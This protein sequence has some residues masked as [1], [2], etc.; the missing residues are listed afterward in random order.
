MPHCGKMFLTHTLCNVFKFCLTHL[1]LKYK[2][3]IAV[4][5]RQKSDY[6]VIRFYKRGGI[7]FWKNVVRDSTDFNSYS[8]LTYRLRTKYYIVYRF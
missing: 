3:Y 1:E 5:Q 7:I 6:K 8:Y 2:S 4:E